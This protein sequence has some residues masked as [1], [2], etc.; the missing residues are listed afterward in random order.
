MATAEYKYRGAQYPI[1][2]FDEAWGVFEDGEENGY[3]LAI[4]QVTK[5]SWLAPGEYI[6]VPAR[7]D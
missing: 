2:P 5:P 6:V 1:L 7:F 4:I 3:S